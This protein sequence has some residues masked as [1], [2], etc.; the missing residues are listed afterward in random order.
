M[1]YHSKYIL[2][3]LT[4]FFV[5]CGKKDAVTVEPHHNLRY[6]EFLADSLGITVFPNK[7]NIF[8]IALLEDN[9]RRS[10]YQEG[11][12]LYSWGD[13]GEDYNM[14]L[15]ESLNAFSDKKLSAVFP[16]S[17]QFSVTYWTSCISGKVTFTS[18][19]SLFGEKPGED[20]SEHFTRCVRHG[21]IRDYLYETNML[22]SNDY[23]IAIP[24][25]VTKPGDPAEFFYSGHVLMSLA[26]SHT[27]PYDIFGTE[28]AFVLKENPTEVC[29][30][31]VLTIKIPVEDTFYLN[32][33]DMS[34]IFDEDKVTHRN[35]VLKGSC[36]ITF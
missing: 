35:R 13:Y 12:H 2:V 9:A 7:N 10:S 17:E 24:R 32:A 34:G 21:A 22:K 31:A 28:Y 27:E 20:I 3:C 15:R 8:T 19:K 14:P 25:N 36:T 18:D 30:S 5:S 23:V 33:F 26:S 4:L 11:V 16:Q 1:S 29:N 6:S